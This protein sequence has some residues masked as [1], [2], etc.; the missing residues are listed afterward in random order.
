VAD[1]VTEEPVAEEPV[2][3]ESEEVTGIPEAPSKK[4]SK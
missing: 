4:S 1:V 3:E 2:A